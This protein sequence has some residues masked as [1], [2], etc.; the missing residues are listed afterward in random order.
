[1]R[2]SF[3]FAVRGPKQGGTLYVTLTVR[4]AADIPETITRA[5][6]IAAQRSD[7]PEPEFV[8]MVPPVR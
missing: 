7:D 2:L 1:V 8:R 3:Q 5:A 4:R 6:R